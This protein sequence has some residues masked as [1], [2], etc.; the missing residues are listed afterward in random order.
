MVDGI[1]HV[2]ATGALLRE[3]ARRHVR[4]QREQLACCEVASVVEC[5]VLTE[6]ARAGPLTAAQLGARLGI[7]KGQLSR[8]LARM[9]RACLL[10]RRPARG[11]ARAS[12]VGLSA[13]GRR[14]HAAL[15]RQ[16]AAHAARVLA[17]L[18]REERACVRRALEL[19]G[20]AYGAGPGACGVEGSG[21]TP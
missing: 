14:R 16:L 4:S 18:T 1:N 10:S 19:L 13:A 17:H 7:D 3:V 9:G 15:D 8:T 6:L 2:A 5:H 11:D 21:G 20:R 12:L